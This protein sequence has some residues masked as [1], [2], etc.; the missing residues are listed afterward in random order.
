MF[1]GSSLAT[2]DFMPRSGLALTFTELGFG[3]A[4]IGNLYRAISNDEALRT[5][6]AAWASGCRYF[7]TAPR[8]GLGLAET[9]LNAFLR[10]HKRDDCVVSTK[11][12]RV[13]RVCPSD[14]R[15][16]IGKFFDTPSRFEHYDYSYDGTMRSKIGR[17]SCRERV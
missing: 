16:Q 8:Y 11:I 4:P 3:S 1:A 10:G 13:L 17:A 14:Q 12:G 2:R 9:R 6:E 15:S 7:D 5:L